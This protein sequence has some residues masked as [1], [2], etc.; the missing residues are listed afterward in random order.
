MRVP[1][2]IILISLLFVSGLLPACEN[3]QQLEK[4]SSDRATTLTER[5]ADG[6]Y[7]PVKA[8]LTDV[9]INKK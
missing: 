6:L 4:Q 8:V 9:V 1:S 2:K 7:G 5:E 3:H